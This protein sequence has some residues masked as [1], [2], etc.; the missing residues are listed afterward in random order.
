[1]TRHSIDPERMAALLDGRLEAQAREQLLAELAKS[2]DGLGTL[3]DTAA[4]L[5]NLELAGVPS[6]IVVPPAN[7]AP[8]VAQPPAIDVVAP[9]PMLLRES[10]GDRVETTKQLKPRSS[11]PWS[12]AIAAGLVGIVGIGLWYRSTGSARLDYPT[13]MIALLSTPEGAHPAPVAWSTTRGPADRLSPSA[14]GV[15]FGARATEIEIAARS[16]DAVTVSRLAA[17]MATLLRG[18]KGSGLAVQLYE[19]IAT[20]S[21][22][23]VDVNQLRERW[24]TAITLLDRESALLGAWLVAAREAVAQRDAGFF[25]KPGSREVI[26]NLSAR[27]PSAPSTERQA[28]VDLESLAQGATPPWEPLDRDLTT[29][30]NALAN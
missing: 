5:R 24:D 23:V 26:R 20:T 14:R 30:L 6:D 3:S 25:Q 11:S 9:K 12:W 10:G 15:R 1:M 18:A 27:I 8:S 22:P 7:D 19:Q 28:V 17:E 2:E 4:L 13:D 21:Q 16:R 29:L